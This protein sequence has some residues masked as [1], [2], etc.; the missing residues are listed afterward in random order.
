MEGIGVLFLAFV[1][2]VLVFL[3][4][5]FI[6]VGLWISAWAAGVRVPLLT[7]VAMRLRR[8]PPAKIIYPLIKATKAGLDVR[9]DR[10]EAHYLAGGKR[11]PGGGRPHR[12]PTRPAS[13]SPLTGRRPLTWRA[14]TC[15]RRCGSP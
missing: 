15:W 4:F 6:P 8:V 14:V 9:L 1:V 2:L 13:S 12:P 5:S 10:L 3:F 11:G 7:L